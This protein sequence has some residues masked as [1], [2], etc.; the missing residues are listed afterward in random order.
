MLKKSVTFKGN[1]SLSFTLSVGPVLK[2]LEFSLKG[3]NFDGWIIAYFVLFL[4]QKV[5]LPQKDMSICL[6]NSIHTSN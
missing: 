4:T 6:D 5:K 3:M 2:V 1:N